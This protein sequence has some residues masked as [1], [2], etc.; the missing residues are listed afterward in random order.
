MSDIEYR[1]LGTV[2]TDLEVRF[3]LALERC[4]RCGERDIGDPKTHWVTIDVGPHLEVQSHWDIT[5][6]RCAFERHVAYSRLRSGG[7]WEPTIGHI[8]GP[9]PS[10][11]IRPEQLVRELLWTLD[12]VDMN[13]GGLKDAS[14]AHLRANRDMWSIALDCVGELLKFIPA[15]EHEVPASIVVTDE[16]R[17]LRAAH[18]AMFTR[19]RLDALWAQLMD[20]RT[21]TMR[22][23]DEQYA[24]KQAAGTV[25][26]V[27][28]LPLPVFSIAALNYHQRWLAE[29]DGEKAQRLIGKGGNARSSNWVGRDFSLADLETCTLDDTMASMTRWNGARLVRCTATE[30]DF[31]GAEMMEATL[32]EVDFTDAVLGEVRLCDSHISGCRFAN[33]WL[34]QTMWYRA[35]VIGC[36]FIGAQLIDAAF[37]HATFVDCDFDGSTL[38]IEREGRLGTAVGVQFIRCNFRNTIWTGR[39][40][41][42]ATFVD[43]TFE[44][45]RGGPRLN[46]TTLERPTPPRDELVLAWGAEVADSAF[47]ELL[48]DLSPDDAFTV[49]Q[50]AEARGLGAKVW[51]IVG[52]GDGVF[53]HWV[54]V[55][56]PVAVESIASEIERAVG[57]RPQ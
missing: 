49:R 6:P 22:I 50:L 24:A 9:E 43:C 15:G 51:P 52:P 28:R 47:R 29:G 17:A 23:W 35:S 13:V 38:E 8:A 16:G 21:E 5:C 26:P 1:Q 39:D 55:R 18:P 36:S 54:R 41:Y 14:D 40:L 37:D 30:C 44:S 32:T 20:V 19:A 34:G 45:A 53:R 3:F 4:P 33:T 25:A 27:G 7:D 12:H 56:E 11:L 2:R 42:R 57:A 31:T 46:E 10:S 48:F